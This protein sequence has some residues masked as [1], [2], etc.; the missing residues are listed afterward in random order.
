MLKKEEDK[1]PQSQEPDSAPGT[2]K[3][4]L[5]R[6]DKKAGDNLN[7]FQLEVNCR[8]KEIAESQ[9]EKEDKKRQVR[10]LLQQKAETMRVRNKLELKRK[11]LE[12]LAY[13]GS[14]EDKS[15]QLLSAQLGSF[16]LIGQKGSVSPIRNPYEKNQKIEEEPILTKQSINDFIIGEHT[17][18]PRAR[19]AGRG[20]EYNSTQFKALDKAFLQNEA[21]AWSIDAEGQKQKVLRMMEHEIKPENKSVEVSLPLI[22]LNGQSSRN[23]GNESAKSPGPLRVQRLLSEVTDTQISPVKTRLI[24]IIA[25]SIPSESEAVIF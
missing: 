20:G 2:G 22:P 18:R 9:R 13:R 15:D 16:E 11:E 12:K 3:A 14:A 8:Q 17:S 4:V 19:M 23:S 25:P 24:Q 6:L 7:K 21:V 1:T 10:S 5:E